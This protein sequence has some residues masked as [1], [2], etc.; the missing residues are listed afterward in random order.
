MLWLLATEVQAAPGTG[1]DTLAE[2][3]EHIDI[4]NESTHCLDATVDL[5]GPHTVGYPEDPVYD[6]QDR[7]T[8]LMRE[9]NDM[10]KRSSWRRT[11]S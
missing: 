7:L 4:N 8:V 6:N 2:D 3:P 10:S 9:I 11:T 1:L 5:G